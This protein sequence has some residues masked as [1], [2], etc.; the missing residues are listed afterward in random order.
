MEFV[1]VILLLFLSEVFLTDPTAGCGKTKLVSTVIDDLLQKVPEDEALAYFYCD[2]DQPDHREP[3]SV[4]RS[5]LR[6]LSVPR[7]NDAIP[8]LTVQMYNQ[9]RHNAFIS[10]KLK[11]RESQAVLTNLFETYSRTTLV[12]DALDE[13][14]RKTRLDFMK[15]V[16][17]SIAESSKP[18]VILISSRQDGDIKR[19]FEDGPSLEIRAIDNRDDIA[20]FV[21]HEVTA[22]KSFW[23][24]Q[25]SPELKELICNT[26]VDGSEGM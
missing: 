3:A 26:L 5:F 20:R 23:R 6:Q 18:V 10:G 17:K 7:N 13:C 12:V 14:D 1:S 21:N 11:L 16:K 25:I 4:L 19:L 22:S 9:K 2:R 8:G 24:D 15:I